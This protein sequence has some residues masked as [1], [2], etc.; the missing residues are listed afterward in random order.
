VNIISTHVKIFFNIYLYNLLTNC[1]FKKVDKHHG[2][3]FLEEKQK[4]LV[5]NETNKNEIRK[6]LGS[7][8]TTSKFDND[9]W[10]YIER[11][12]TQSELKNLGRMKLIKND[13]LVLEIDNRG[14]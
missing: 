13:V 9:V 12:L 14:F 2:V 8:S 3:P 4:L 11:K 10:I 7:P 5:V 1:T 6:I